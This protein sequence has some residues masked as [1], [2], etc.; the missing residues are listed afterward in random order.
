MA[1]P[2]AAGVAQPS[3]VPCWSSRHN[4]SG[5]I[6]QAPVTRNESKMSDPKPQSP[7]PV[8]ISRS[9]EHDIK[10]RWKDG[11]ETVYPARF[12]RM[13]C[14][15]AVCVDELSGVRRLQESMV[16]SG[17]HPAGID[18]VGRYAIQIHWSDGHGTGIYTWE[19]LHDLIHK[20]PGTPATP[21]QAK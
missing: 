18:P 16:P 12:L 14:P 10:I 2:V 15:C 20:I 9:G 11:P 21:K 1:A 19:R 13:E 6:L 3:C 7:K 17:V 4:M 5:H 8:E